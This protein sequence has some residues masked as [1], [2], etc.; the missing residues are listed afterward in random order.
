MGGAGSEQLKG[1]AGSEQLNG[2][3]V[4]VDLLEPRR[5]AD[6]ARD[7]PTVARIRVTARPASPLN[8]HQSSTPI[9]AES[10]LPASSAYLR[11]S[12][13]ARA[14]SRFNCS[15][16]FYPFYPFHRLT[17]TEAAML[18]GFGPTKSIRAMGLRLSRTMRCVAVRV[19][20]VPTSSGVAAGWSSRKRAI[21]PLT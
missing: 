6:S 14:S 12:K 20:K 7:Y 17:S 9:H 4:G 15:D 18:S 3:D 21:A 2:D 5:S 8:A 19:T 11:R 16:P 1:K 10:A 13:R